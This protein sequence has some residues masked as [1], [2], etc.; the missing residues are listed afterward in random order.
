LFVD[1]RRF[2]DRGGITQERCYIQSPNSKVVS[3]VRNESS[4]KIT[5]AMLKNTIA[6]YYVPTRVANRFEKGISSEVRNEFRYST[7]SIVA[8]DFKIVDIEKK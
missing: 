3:V 6:R 8:D 2:E 1:Y 5:E 7:Y 4:N